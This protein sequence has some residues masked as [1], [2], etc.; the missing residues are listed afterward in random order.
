MGLSEGAIEVQNG[1]VTNLQGGFEFEGIRIGNEFTF[2]VVPHGNG[3][4]VVTVPSVG[5]DG[6]MTL[7]TYLGDET[8][9]QFAGFP[10]VTLASDIVSPTGAAEVAVSVEFSRA[11]VGFGQD[12]VGLTNATLSSFAEIEAGLSYELVV[13]PVDVGAVVVALPDGAGQDAENGL[14]SRAASYGFE[15][16][17]ANVLERVDLTTFRL[18]AGSIPPDPL[19][20]AS[21]EFDPELDVVSVEE[22]S[23]GVYLI[24]TGFPGHGDE[25]LPGNR[26][27]R[28]RPGPDGGVRARRVRRLLRGGGRRDGPSLAS[29]SMP[30]TDWGMDSTA[31]RMDRWG[32]NPPCVLSMPP[33]KATP[34]SWRAMFAAQTAL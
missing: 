8:S 21:Y 11:V 30:P 32:I 25:L 34:S 27:W 33:A 9:F 3:Q 16:L 1:V 31:R 4:V 6:I 20:P 10:D 5:A 19:N 28:G 12:D 7:S 15:H 17:P 18:R 14:D 13:A 23:P 2:D 22:E 24:R 29:R 26:R